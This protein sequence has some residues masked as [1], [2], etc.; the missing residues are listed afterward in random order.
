MT[1]VPFLAVA[2]GA[3]ALSLLTRRSALVSGAIGVAGLMLAALVAMGIDADDTM[4]IGGGKLVGS[5]Y[6]RLFVTLGSIVALTLAILG[7]ATTTHRHAPGVLLGGIGAAGLALALPDARIAVLAASAGGL[8][9]I[10]VTVAAPAT[11]RSVVV[12]SRELRAIAVAGVL[13]VLA[14]AWIGRSLGELAAEPAVFGM[15]YLGF[16][17][18]V[19]I[20]FGAIPFHFWAARLADAAP[21]VTLPMLMAWSPAAFAVVALAWADQSVAP[22]VLPLAAER[23]LILAVGAVSIVLGSVAAWIQDDL[24]HVVGYL[25]IADA[26]VAIL[27]LAALQPEAWEPA[28]TWVLSFVVVR[29][30]FAAWAVALRS[31]FGTRRIPD[32]RGWAI[33]APGLGVAFVVIAVAGIAWPGLASWNARATLIDLTL[34]GPFYLLVTLGALAPI[35]VYG[36]L[37][38]VGLER[39]AERLGTGFVERPALPAVPAAVRGRGSDAIRALAATVLEVGRLNRALVASVLVGLLAVL[40][41]TVSAGGLGVVD[42]ARAVPQQVPRPSDSGASP[43]PSAAPSEE[44]TDGPSIR[45]TEPP[46]SEPSAGASAVS[47]SFQPLPSASP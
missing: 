19:A 14:A 33:R 9:G 37:A 26:G 2:F 29:S 34:D 41:F 15:A 35:A 4:T 28:R 11:A 42:A 22:L 3:G 44:P 24:E 45:P 36:R 17:A 27:G 43:G 32:L 16:A 23:G 12:A 18:A 21:E 1:I 40:S 39:P 46:S 25:I 8:I 5:A 38:M 10:L 6:L 47:P 7:F 30:A 31:A 13:A 20:R